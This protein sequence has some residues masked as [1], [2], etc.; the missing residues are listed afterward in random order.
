MPFLSEMIKGT[1]ILTIAG[2]LSRFLGFY[3]RIYLSNIIGARE[4]G[5]YQLIFPVYI[6][7]IS[8]CCGGIQTALSKMVS[9]L[10]TK[11]EYNKIKKLMRLALCF[12]LILSVF[13]TA[14]VFFFS[15]QI[16]AYIIKEPSCA[17]SLR[18][19]ICALPFVTMKSCLHGYS[20]GL[21]KSGI[22]AASQLLEQTARV[23]GIYLLSA[24]VSFRFASAVLAAY[25][26]IIGEVTSFL[27]TIILYIFSQKK[28]EKRLTHESAHKN[29]QEDR[30]KKNDT[31]LSLLKSLLNNS[32]PL[33]ANRL[34]L[35]LL[36]ST[37]AILIPSMLKIFYKDSS[38]SLELYGIL[39]GMALPF[40]LFPATLTNAL[41]SML[42]PTI[43]AAKTKNHEKTISH[44]TS[45]TIHFCMSIGIMST[46][47]FLLYGKDLGTV[48]FSN[49]TAGEILFLLALL[50][51]FLYIS[52]SLSSI[53]NG[54]GYAATTLWHNLIS[55]I[56]HIAFIVLFIP[57][58]GI[59]GYIWGL[60]ASYIVLLFLDLIKLSS[61][62]E[63]KFSVI[64][65]IFLP[66]FF[67]L[68]AGFLSTSF[69][70]YFALSFCLGDFFSL[71]I[72]CAIFGGVCAMTM[73]FLL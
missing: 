41:S 33:T 21:K 50:C 14:I 6:V 56:I 47:L 36:E 24:V 51:P 8:I 70:E 71:F 1:L 13:L 27:Y 35:T 17:P 16:S 67:S 19:A 23:S 12:C 59:K 28:R 42:L 46:F 15:P 68:L 38:L 20:I 4:L 18:V 26:M 22:P 66:C 52:S 34:S 58:V 72:A 48:I 61:L 57:L 10:S 60:L 9:S 32:I 69:S 7:C 49:E 29:M 25:G 39:T 30:R 62:V 43:S 63:I 54:L 65:T 44:T 37:E 5:I 53:L 55:S 2:F 40:L 64:K 31:S 45:K 73:L 11:N 3:N